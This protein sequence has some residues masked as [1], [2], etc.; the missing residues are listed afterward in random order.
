MIELDRSLFLTLNSIHSPFFDEVMWFFSLKTVWIP[1]Y[2]FIIYLLVRKYRGKVWII[3]VFAII[4][5][6]LTD[7]VSVLIKNTVERLRPCHEPLIDG[8][9]H[10][11]RGKCGGMYGFVSSHAA[12]T[13]GVASFTVP[14]VQ[15]KWYSWTIFIWA[16][17]VSYSRIYLGVHY[18]GDIIGGII[19]GVFIGFGLSIIVKQI[20]KSQ[21]K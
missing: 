2:L 6:L 1:L 18:P 14:L 20:Y 5:V 8:L 19:L 15:K 11:V 3:L 21:K 16:A 9:V 7:Q 17:I 10:I 4:L 12:N 13:F